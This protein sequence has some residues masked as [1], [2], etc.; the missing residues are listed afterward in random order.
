MLLRPSDDGRTGFRSV[1][2]RLASRSDRRF[3][4][5]DS[6]RRR[7]GFLDIRADADLEDACLSAAQLAVEK[8]LNDA[9]VKASEVRH[10]FPPQVSSSFITLLADRL[11]VPREKMVDVARDDGDLFTSSLPCALGLHAIQTKRCR[12]GDVC[13]V[14]AVGA[15]IQATA[16]LYYF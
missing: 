2:I 3:T 15:G 10:F 1:R 16:A 14:V 8:L 5:P 4:N 6:I 13:V 9:G 12:S 11:Q 7:R